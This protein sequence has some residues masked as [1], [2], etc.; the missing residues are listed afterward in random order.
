MRIDSDTEDED[1]YG[2]TYGLDDIPASDIFDSDT[3]DADVYT[4]IVPRTDLMIY[5][6]QIFLNMMVLRPDSDYYM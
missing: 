4:C 2:A 5:K 6:P 3:E 1:V